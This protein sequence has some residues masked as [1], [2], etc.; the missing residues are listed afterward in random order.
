MVQCARCGP[1][2][3]VARASRPE[4][5]SCHTQTILWLPCPIASTTL[6]AMATDYAFLLVRRATG[7]RRGHATRGETRGEQHKQRPTLVR[8]GW[9]SPRCRVAE[10]GTQQL[11][12]AARQKKAQPSG[13]HRHPSPCRKGP[14]SHSYLSCVCTRNCQPQVMSSDG[15]S[16]SRRGLRACAETITRA[17]VIKQTEQNK[18]GEGSLQ[19]R[20]SPRPGA[21]GGRGLPRALPLALPVPDQRRLLRP[22]MPGRFPGE[23]IE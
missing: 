19:P 22:R 21:H 10:L 1:E 5:K 7:S 14:W 16:S 13:N 4:K 23:E 11:G 3:Y 2:W 17:A 15:T 18:K 8:G 9:R 20:G 12:L 6:H